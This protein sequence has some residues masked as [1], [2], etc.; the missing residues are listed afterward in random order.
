MSL[1]EKDRVF[2]GGPYFY[3]AAGLYMRPCVMKFIPTRETFT[4]VLVW[5]RLYSLP[6]DYWL[7]ES[8]KA[9]GNKIG[10]F[11]KISDGTLR[12]KYTS[13]TWICVE[14]DLSGALPKEIILEVYDEEWVQTADYENIPFRCC[15]CHEHGHLFKDCPIINMEGNGKT[16]VDRNQ[17]GFTKVG[18]KGKGSKR[19]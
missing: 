5:I 19:P 10:H 2:E 13:F 6:L 9:I 14:M 11:I 3:A 18:S 4:S 12:A 7:L 1:E 16:T 17:E 15:K 8:L